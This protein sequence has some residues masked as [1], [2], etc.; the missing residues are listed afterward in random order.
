MSIIFPCNNP[1]GSSTAIMQCYNIGNSVQF[2]GQITN[3]P[4]L[5]ISGS[6]IITTNTSIFTGFVRRWNKI[7][8]F[9]RI[10]IG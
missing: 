6:T 3:P 4:N 10:H 2:T 7:F 9:K 5:E 1:S 8:I